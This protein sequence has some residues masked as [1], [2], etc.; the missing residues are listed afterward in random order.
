VRFTL[1]VKSLEK[2]EKTYPIDGKILLD[3]L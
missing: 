2:L 1:L 3:S